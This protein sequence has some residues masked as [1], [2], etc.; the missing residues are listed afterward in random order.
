M[1]E[2]LPAS[3]HKTCGRQCDDEDCLGGEHELGSEDSIS[4]DALPAGSAHFGAMEASAED[5]LQR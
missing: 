5:G 1:T 3:M 2:I 4:L